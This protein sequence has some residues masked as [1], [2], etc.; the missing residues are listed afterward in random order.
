MTHPSR[1]DLPRPAGSD[2]RGGANADSAA[3]RLPQARSMERNQARRRRMRQAPKRVARRFVALPSRMSPATAIVVILVVG[4][5]ALSLATPLRNY[6]EQRT[7]L[8]QLQST[9]QE[10]ER[11]KA[12]LQAELN[13]FENED[14][15]KEQARIRL[16]VIEPGES[17]YRI[18]SPKIT[19][20][21]G[22]D[23][24]G[25][26]KSPSEQEYE[27]SPW[28]KKLWDSVAVEPGEES[29]GD[30]G[31]APAGQGEDQN[32]GANLEGAE[33]PSD[34]MKLPTLPENQP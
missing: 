6:Y 8:A 4:L 21:A 30:V 17:A 9:I 22:A 20:A 5:M 24:P 12:E 34:D 14:Y 7:E 23:A 33:Q 31:R 25:A 10:Q 2:Q 16:G 15:L 1:D 18:I 26:G 32:P 27:N 11:H 13:R 3:Q 28:F 19:G 29:P